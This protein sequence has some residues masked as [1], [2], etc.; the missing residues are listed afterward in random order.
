MLPKSDYERIYTGSFIN[1]Q[2]LQSILEERGIN[3]VKRDD[4]ESGLR[5]GFG[6]GLPN[7]VQLFVKKKDILIAKALVEKKMNGPDPS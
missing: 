3:S 1:V 7:Q 2:Y 6:G 5:G 4:F